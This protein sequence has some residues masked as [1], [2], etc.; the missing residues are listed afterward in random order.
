MEKIEGQGK[1]KFTLV[2]FILDLLT[3]FLNA[4]REIEARL[5]LILEILA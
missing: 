2:Q 5:K 4:L 3:P 1:V